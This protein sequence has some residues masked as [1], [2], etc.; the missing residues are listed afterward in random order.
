MASYALLQGERLRA[1]E[2][3]EYYEY[4][5]G[6]TRHKAPDSSLAARAVRIRP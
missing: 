4:Y 3:Y 6:K 1:Y 5:T 2:H